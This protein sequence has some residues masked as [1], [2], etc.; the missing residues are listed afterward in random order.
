MTAQAM[1]EQ[2]EILRRINHVRER[3]AV[4]AYRAGRRPEEITLLAVTKTVDPLRIIQAHRAGV[5]HFGENRIQEAEEKFSRM[6]E[7]RQEIIWHFIGHLQSNKVRRA[8]SLFHVIQSV[9]RAGLCHKIDRIAGER[10]QR[11]S[12]YLQVD[13][14]SEPTKSGAPVE[15]LM[16]LAE[17]VAAC[18][19]VHPV[20]LMTIPPY[21]EDPEHARPYFAKLRELL[22]QLNQRKIFDHPL[23]GLSMGMSHDFDAAIAEGAT[24]VRVGTAIFGPRSHEER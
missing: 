11:A 5:R 19:Y 12:I 16:A 6:A 15:G 1:I 23:T 17:Q 18:R 13:L 10:G 24:I 9:D 14:A 8:V 2:N 20:G 4:A 3:M 7:S 22:E 21:C